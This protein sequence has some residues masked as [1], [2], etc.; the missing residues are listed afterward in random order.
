MQKDISFIN[1]Y[2]SSSARVQRLS[3]ALQKVTD[4]ATQLELQKLLLSSV[5]EGWDVE[6]YEEIALK[7]EEPLDQMWMDSRRSELNRKYD[8]LQGDLNSAKNAV[9]KPHLRTSNRAL[10]DHFMK[11]GNYSN[12]LKHY[13]SMKPFLET[14]KHQEEMCMSCILAAI[15]CGQWE[16]A[17][18]CIAKLGPQKDIVMNAKLTAADALC[19]L[20][21][22][23]YRSAAQKF[24]KVDAAIE[25][26]FD[27]IILPSDIAYY[28]IICA[29]ASLDRA[30]L[31]A[32]VDDKTIKPCH[33]LVPKIRNV[34]NDYFSGNL[35]ACI[36]T[37]ES[38]RPRMSLDI[39]MGDHY[40]KLMTE[41]VEQIAIQY[42]TPFV[43][44][45]INKMA[46]TMGMSVDSLEMTAAKYVKVQ[47]AYFFGNMKCEKVMP[48]SPD[49]SLVQ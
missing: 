46:A 38:L 48:H 26:S 31:K 28:A 34:V 35:G 16:F 15:Q 7:I 36:K 39:Y 11:I 10:G 41:V 42:F 14:S 30:S 20:A 37:L 2:S 27:D 29:L 1:Q 23:R 5:K 49:L 19:D 4:S 25:D 24:M 44:A 12:A 43:S 6:K 40:D 45:D 22:F 17:Q 3:Y 33:E 47:D 9:N 21:K 13:D 18:K 32:L 8:D